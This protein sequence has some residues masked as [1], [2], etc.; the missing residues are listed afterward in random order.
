MARGPAAD[1]IV[2]V[3]DRDMIFVPKGRHDEIDQRRVILAE[4]ARVLDADN[5]ADA[6]QLVRGLVEAIR[7][8]PEEGRLRIGVRGELGAILRLAE[9]A[10]GARNGKR[11]GVEAEALFEQI[12]LDAGTGF[13]PVTFRL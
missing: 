6:R 1:Q 2:P 5:A 3:I 9:G 4:L 7:L 10:R 13:E 12:K 11:L 8:I